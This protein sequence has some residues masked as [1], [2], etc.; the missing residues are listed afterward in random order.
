M[1]AKSTKKR[2]STKG[3]AK[4]KQESAVL[5]DEIVILCM[6]AV[7]ILLL[8][9]NFGLGGL[10]GDFV[11]SVMFGV[12]GWIAYLIPL[13]LFGVVAFLI[14]NR[15]NSHA[16][17]KAAALSVLIISVAAFLELIINSYVQGTQLFS[18]YQQASAHKNAG[19]LIGG[20]V[21]TVMYFV[22]TLWCLML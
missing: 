16:Y 20:C 10:A 18:Y 11:S 22:T 5:H 7:C 3:S 12:F 17:I 8:I 9:S 14:S 1:A 4:K 15:G 6:L 13:I 19:G 21:I 2:K